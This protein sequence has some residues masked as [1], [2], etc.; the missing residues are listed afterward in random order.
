MLREGTYN[1]LLTENIFRQN[2][3]NS[4]EKQI[5]KNRK[6][7]KFNQKNILL[8]K[9]ILKIILNFLS[10]SEILNFNLT[11]KIYGSC[12]F[13]SFLNGII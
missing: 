9:E 2:N 13:K 7:N 6:I 8:N 5:K 3:I 1:S 12:I 11:S 10:F 4:S